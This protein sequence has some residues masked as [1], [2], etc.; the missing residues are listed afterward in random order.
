MLFGGINVKVEGA[1]ELL[2]K[3]CSE[4]NG[5]GCRQLGNHFNYGLHEEKVDKERARAL[6]KKACQLD[7]AP[8]CVDLGDKIK[9]GKGGKPDLAA[10]KKW[11]E[12][13]CALEDELA[14]TKVGRAKKGF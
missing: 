7:F 1:A 12:K 14:C 10:A 6:Y 11:Y 4:G 8:A 3:S 5:S 13:G 9:R 2:E